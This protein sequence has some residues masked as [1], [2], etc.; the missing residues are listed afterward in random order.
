ML[1]PAADGCKCG[2]AGL[3]D[4]QAH[5]IYGQAPAE[6][7]EA[8]PL[9]NATNRVERRARRHDAAEEYD[10][11]GAVATLQAL[12]TTVSAYGPLLRP[13]DRGMPERLP[14]PARDAVQRAASA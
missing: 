3:V 2:L 4:E 10:H 12:A 14:R 11:G 7:R 5:P 6:R 13:S 1:A 8:P 9:K